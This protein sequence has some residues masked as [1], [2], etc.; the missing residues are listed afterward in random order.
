MKIDRFPCPRHT[1][2]VLQVRETTRLQKMAYGK[3]V[4]EV[5]FNER[6][7]I[8]CFT[9]AGFSVCSQFP[10]IPY[11]LESVLGES[12]ETK[13]YLCEVVER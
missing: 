6:H 3:L 2:P 8:D 4:F 1:V 7:L 10:S 5:I 11:D 12:T 9:R 13:T